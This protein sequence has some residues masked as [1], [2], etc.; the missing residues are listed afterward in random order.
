MKT[1]MFALCLIVASFLSLTACS[2]EEYHFRYKANGT[3]IDFPAT[4][5]LSPDDI[6]IDAGNC[7]LKIVGTPAPGQYTMDPGTSSYFIH[8]TGAVTTTNGSSMTVTVT[9][10]DLDVKGTFSGTVME[11][12]GTSYSITDGSFFLKRI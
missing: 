5:N 9:L 10:A 8:A 4:C 12:S 6:T 3:L 2:K 7:R 11:T 1:N